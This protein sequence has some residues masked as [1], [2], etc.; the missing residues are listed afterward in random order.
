MGMRT[1]RVIIEQD[2]DGLFIGSVPEL[3]GCHA[4]GTTRE[5]LLANVREAAALCLEVH[6]R[7]ISCAPDGVCVCPDCPDSPDSPDSPDPMDPAAPSLAKPD[8]PP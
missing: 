6:G 2:E 3:P 1:F 4:Q 5:E 7:E 8:G